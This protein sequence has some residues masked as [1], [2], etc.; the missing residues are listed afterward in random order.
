[1]KNKLVRQMIT[2]MSVAV[3]S[4]ALA[5]SGADVAPVDSQEVIITE[6]DF[7]PEVQEETTADLAEPTEVTEVIAGV[8]G[9]DPVEEQ[10]TPIEE[11]TE[12]VIV[13]EETTQ[14]SVQLSSLI[15][16]G[17]GG[18]FQD[19]SE[20]AVMTAEQWNVETGDLAAIEATEDTQ[21]VPLFQVGPEAGS[22]RYVVVDAKYPAYDG[23]AAISLVN[24][25]G[26]VILDSTNAS[27]QQEWHAILRNVPM[28]DVSLLGNA[29]S[30][31]NYSLSWTA[32]YST[33]GEGEY[34]EP[35]R[36]GYHFAGWYMDADANVAWDAS[37]SGV[38]YANWIEDATPVEEAT[39]DTTDEQIAMAVLLENETT[40]AE[41]D[42]SS[43]EEVVKAAEDTFANHDAQAVD[44]AANAETSAT[45]DDKDDTAEATS[46]A[47]TVQ[48]LLMDTDGVNYTLKDTEH[49]TAQAGTQVTPSVKTYEGFSSPNIQTATI[50]ADGST[51]VE[52][53][54]TR[55]SYNFTLTQVEGADLSGST[56]SGSRYYQEEIT[57]KCVPSSGYEFVQWSNEDTSPVTTILMPAEDLTIAPKLTSATYTITYDLDG[58]EADNP[59]TYTAETESFRLNQPTKEG[60]IFA[61]WTGANG[62]TPQTQVT[63]NK[64][65]TGNLSFAATWT[66]NGSI[67]PT[68]EETNDATIGNVKTGDTTNMI[69]YIVGIGASI[70]VILFLVLSGKKK[71]NK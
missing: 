66:A 58:G 22:L 31:M 37:P 60:Y 67:T 6:E 48:H 62:S 69:P 3:L 68:P 8:V 13:T 19:G 16:D 54:Y 70:L 1:M 49:L 39:E 34:A 20:T 25:E 32:V 14:P 51:V 45:E 30:D 21:Y 56:P 47:Y 23:S 17:N 46:T 42:S 57:L 5:V 26:T 29:A 33:S 36:E 50:A 63:I 43:E 53:R 52:Y 24:A 64:G 9:S 15:F 11:E 35:I 27:A 12:D 44:N 2:L 55:L 38:V 59:T 65:T 61:G 28:L 40:E 10:T 7:A 18:Y 71:K 41:E 4:S